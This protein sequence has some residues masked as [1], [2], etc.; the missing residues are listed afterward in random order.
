MKRRSC[1]AEL[2]L[3]GLEG[4]TTLNRA[5]LGYHAGFELDGAVDEDESM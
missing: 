1:T 5:Q 4:V 2:L 3:R